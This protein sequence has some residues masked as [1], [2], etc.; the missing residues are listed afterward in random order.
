M[1]ETVEQIVLWFQERGR[2]LPWRDE[3]APY[4]IWV[5]EI[6]LQQ[7]R[8]EAVVPYYFRFLAAFPTVEAL[9]EAEDGRLMKLWEGLGYYS[10]ARNLK[11][12]A[13]LLVSERNGELPQTAKELRQLPGIGEYTAGAIASIAFGEPEPAVDGNV[14]RVV[15]RATASDHTKQTAAEL[16]RAVYPT[17][18]KAGLLTEGLMELGETICA[19]NGEPRC[20]LCPIQTRCRAYL[21]G[22]TTRYPAKKEKKPRRIERRTVFLLHDENGFGYAIRKRKENGLLAGLWELPNQEGFLTEEEALRTAKDMGF[23]AQDVRPLGK[24]RHVFSHVEWDMIGFAMTGAADATRLFCATPE[25]IRLS[26]ALP[27]AFRF[28][29]EKM[30]SE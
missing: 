20:A 26:Y 13:Q 11:K 7:T 30:E 14:L 12:A 18:E 22:A 3:P 9:A 25:E 21:T 24:A 1:R 8:I 15:S 23:R 29:A 6:M 28:Y 10:R 5:S 16:L 2:S 19:P 27:A 4:H 17:G